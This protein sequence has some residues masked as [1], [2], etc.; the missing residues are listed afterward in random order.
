MLYPPPEILTFA[1]YRYSRTGVSEACQK[2]NSVNAQYQ[3]I[4]KRKQI[5]DH[6]TPHTGNGNPHIE[7]ILPSDNSPYAT[8]ADN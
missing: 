3:L 4:D 1:D 7:A 5:K 2:N 6:A 8:G